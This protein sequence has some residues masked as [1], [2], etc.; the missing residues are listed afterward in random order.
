MI[1]T[2]IKKQENTLEW[3]EIII[4]YIYKSIKNP[5]QKQFKKNKP[6][7]ITIP[8]LLDYP[9]LSLGHQL[10]LFL[11]ENGLE[12]QPQLEDHDVFHV[13]TRSGL[14][15]K[16]EIE[17]QFYLLGNGK[18]SLF[19]FIVIATGLFFYPLSY[20]CFREQY[21]KGKKAHT[22]YNL[23]FEKLLS[24]P[25]LQLQFTFNIN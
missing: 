19:L 10:G 2:L 13:L 9:S 15:V 16:N 25:L 14:M 3:R 20:K 6:W 1:I 23:D 7:N 17:L 12:I 11:Q 8:V 5:Y 4:E 24:I 18:R 21:Q 22:F